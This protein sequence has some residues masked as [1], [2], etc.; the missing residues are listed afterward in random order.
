MI[1]AVKKIQSSYMWQLD[2]TSVGGMGWKVNE[3]AA[4]T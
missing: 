1:H 2:F 3:N 4:N